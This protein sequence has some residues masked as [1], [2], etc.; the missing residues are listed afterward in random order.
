MEGDEVVERLHYCLHQAVLYL[1]ALQRGSAMSAAGL[2]NHVSRLE[3]SLVAHQP[4][5]AWRRDRVGCEKCLSG[6]SAPG[7][8]GLRLDLHTKSSS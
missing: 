1:M 5:Q 6:R 4:S 8:V 7:E 2:S 3:L